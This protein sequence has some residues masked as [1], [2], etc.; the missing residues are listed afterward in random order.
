MAHTFLGVLVLLNAL[1]GHGE[2][3]RDGHGE[4]S[5]LQAPG[6]LTSQDERTY[7]RM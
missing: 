7:L 6:P 3:R 1:F 2:D 5:M 4:R